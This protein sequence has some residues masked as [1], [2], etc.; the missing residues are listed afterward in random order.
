[1]IFSLERDTK[2]QKPESPLLP[3][4]EALQIILRTRQGYRPLKELTKEDH[5]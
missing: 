4:S 1:M 3:H 5:P 2:V